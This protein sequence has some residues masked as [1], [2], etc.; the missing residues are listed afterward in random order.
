MEEQKIASSDVPLIDQT[1]DIIIHYSRVSSDGRT[2][3]RTDKSETLNLKA[4]KIEKEKLPRNGLNLI[5]KGE[6]AAPVKLEGLLPDDHID[7][8]RYLF[9]LSGKYIDE[10]DGDTRGRLN[11]PNQEDFKKTF[12]D[13]LFPQEEIL[14]EDI[15]DTANNTIIGLY[16]EI[17]NKGKEKELEIEKLKA[18]FLLS[19]ESIRDAKIKLSDTEEKILEKVYQADA[20]LIAKKDAEIKKRIDALD[21]LN[22][23]SKEF[24]ETLNREV[25]ELVKALPSQNKIALTHYV[26][27]R[28]LVLQLFKKVLGRKLTVQQGEDR[29]ADEKLLHNILF[30][31]KSNDPE[32]SDLW[33]LNE[34]FIYFSG[35]SDTPLSQVKINGKKIF[36]KEFAEEEEKYLKSGSENRKIKR[37]DVLLFP[38]EGKCILLEFK[39]PAVNVSEH[40]SQTDFYAYLIR[41]YTVETIHITTFYSYLIGE[42][43]EPKDVRGHVST[44]EHSYHFDYLFRPA[45]KVV[46]ES[47]RTDG[48][49]YSEVIKFSTLIERAEKRNEIFIKKLTQ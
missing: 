21:H 25:E 8:K 24:R 43:I 41:N 40:L 18:M 15:Q 34:D 12:G 28:K 19:P 27:R 2:I 6:V 14:M 39:D 23:N 49:I 32:Q 38:A 33:I 44:Y 9:L 26:A 3:E 45:V 16:E 46:G 47:P 42:N 37:P 1:K 5:S 22:P 48:S 4:F 35:T 7:G 29:S 10:R 36:K 30:P 17:K 20:K 31:Q 11:I 13:T